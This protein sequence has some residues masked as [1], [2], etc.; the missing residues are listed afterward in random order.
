MKKLCNLS[1]IILVMISCLTGCNSIGEKSTN[2]SVIYVAT[3]IFSLL[4][5]IGYCCL[6]EKKELWFY[7][8]FSSVFIVNMGYLSLAIS[9]NL[10][11]ALLAN[12]I[13]YLGSVF[14]PLSML[15]IIMD[16]CKIKCK[17]IFLGILLSLSIIVFIIAA[18]PGYLNIYYKNID[19]EIVNGMSM[20][21]K[22]YGSWHKIYLFYLLLYFTLMIYV[23]IHASNKKKIESK[24]HSQVLLIAVFVNI[25][26]WFLEQIVSINF[27]F[28]SVSYIITELFLLGLHMFIQEN[29]SKQSNQVNLDVQNTSI[30]TTLT[31]TENVD[32]SKNN[33]YTQDISN[34]IPVEQNFEDNDV[35]KN[36]DDLINYKYFETQLKYLTPKE[37]EIYNLYVSGKKT[38][39]II[40]E[41]NITE[42]T[43]KYHNKNI[44]SKLG[45]NSRKQ[46]LEFTTAIELLYATKE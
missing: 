39:E 29:N 44:Y 12:R 13:S 35:N 40:E 33:T 10:E 24:V 6:I 17:K 34:E 27:E 14:L 5:L 23:I 45:V 25:C 42:N 15:M 31:D 43:L 2:M 3:A 9:K 1:I 46:L 18:S 22:E 7:V 19:F 26:V 36:E 28:L 11:E 4:L 37:Q 21:V 38:K 41:L 20:L 30:S 8:L 16:T 32:I